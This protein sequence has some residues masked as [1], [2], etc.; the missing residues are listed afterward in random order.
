MSPFLLTE[1]ELLILLAAL[2]LGPDEAYTVTIA[3]EIRKRTG[4]AVRR[5]NIFTALVRLEE[6]GLV[7]S[8]IGEPRTGRAGRPPRLVR[9]TSRGV[10]AAGEM[11]RGIRALAGD[12]VL[13]DA[14]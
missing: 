3:K 7:E 2:R 1:F 6:N 13:G 10:E 9:V 4:R 14:R 8:R 11:T 12:L 5:S